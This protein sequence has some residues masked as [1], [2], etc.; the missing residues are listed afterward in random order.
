MYRWNTTNLKDLQKIEELAV[1]ISTHRN[2][3][4]DMN[5]VLIIHKNLFSLGYN[6]IYFV[7]DR[8]HFFL[9]NDL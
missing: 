8:F 1:C 7:A 2:W 5:K 6:F 3:C 4:P 9:W